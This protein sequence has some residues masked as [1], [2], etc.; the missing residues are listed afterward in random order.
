MARTLY[1]DS[2]C[3]YGG[4]QESLCSLVK[5]RGAEEQQMLVAG[6]NELNPNIT[7]ETH[8]YMPNLI[9]L[10][11]LISDARR[12]R[13]KI[14]EAIVSFRPDTIFLNTM[15][16]A[17]FWICLRIRT[18]AKVIV[19][20]RD[21]RCPMLL[22]RMLEAFL[23]PMVLAV[24]RRV[25]FKWAFLPSDRLSVLPNIFDVDE[26]ASVKP[27][28][29]PFK[30]GSLN[31]IMAADFTPWK[32][33]VLLLRAMDIVRKKCPD[34]KCLL[35]GRVHTDKDA[36]YLIR[37]RRMLEKLGLQECV[38]INDND[39]AALPYIGA[40]DCLVSCSH[41]EPFGRI[42]VEALAMG[43]PVAAT[44]YGA[45]EELL[46]DCPA[47]SL[48]QET[49]ES[50]ADAILHWRNPESRREARL[51]ALERAGRYKG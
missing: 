25:A 51:A 28:V 19:N 8:H 45:D 47:I 2:T 18:N 17:L 20:D 9:G 11:Q 44:I 23:H 32:N 36:K 10:W 48:A 14:K 22:P 38:F 21:V 46:A 49:S 7:I 33:H 31:V 42:V 3:F 16:S 24:S 5:K 26:I 1:I 12:S 30:P 27:A 50:L 43:K 29:L 41:L 35:K 4:A 37:L 13:C 15:R 6:C 40:S 34:A 39:E